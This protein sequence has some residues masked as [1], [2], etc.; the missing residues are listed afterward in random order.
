MQFS[1]GDQVCS[2]QGRDAGK[3]FLVVGILDEAYVLISDGKHRRMDNPKKKKIKH[4]AFSGKGSLE[5][6]QKL[7]S[8][9]PVTDSNI[10]RALK[11][12][13]ANNGEE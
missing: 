13:N 1:L 2:T 7:I 8:Q 11:N 10:R 12:L 5:I 3:C 9:M 6:A 4:L